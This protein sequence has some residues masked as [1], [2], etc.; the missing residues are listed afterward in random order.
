MNLFLGASKHSVFP[1]KVCLKISGIE[2]EEK[3]PPIYYSKRHL[4]DSAVLQDSI[5][6]YF[7][8]HRLR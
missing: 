3:W 4:L 2:K 8:A 1:V 7:E 6:S 5:V